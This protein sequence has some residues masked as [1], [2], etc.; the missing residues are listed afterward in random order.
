MKQEYRKARRQEQT[1]VEQVLDFKETVPPLGTLKVERQEMDE[2]REG[3]RSH[4]NRVWPQDKGEKIWL[5]MDGWIW[6]F[7]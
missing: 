3:R 2:K 5:A 7:L 6:I 4:Y 1:L